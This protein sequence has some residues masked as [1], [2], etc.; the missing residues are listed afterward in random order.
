MKNLLFGIVILGIAFHSQAGSTDVKSKIKE[1]TVFLQGAQISRVAEIQLVSGFSD[2]VFTEL[3]VGLTESSIQVKAKESV[4]IL[5]V[6]YR[7]NDNHEYSDESQISK[8]DKEI[9]NKQFEINK[10]RKQILVYSEEEKILLQNSSFEGIESGVNLEELKLAADYFRARLKEIA[11]IKLDF[12]QEL[13]LLQEESNRL[14]IQK[15]QIQNTRPEPTGEI[16][17]RVETEV[18]GKQKFEI[19]YFIHSAGWIPEYDVRVND[20][21]K[22]LVISVKAK[23][24]QNSG[25]DWEKVSLVLSTD[26]PQKSNQKPTLSP[27]LLRYGQ[28]YRPT[29]VDSPGKGR[30]KGKIVD[31]QTGE[32]LAFANV[33]LESNGR[34]VAGA[35][36]DYD[37]NYIFQ[38]VD[39]GYYDLKVTYVGFQ[40]SFTKGLIVNNDQIRFYD[41]SLESSQEQLAEIIVTDFAIPL[42]DSD[43]ISSGGTLTAEELQRMPNRNNDVLASDVGGIFEDNNVRGARN[44]E[45]LMYV[46]GMRVIGSNEYVPQ[47]QIETPTNIR[48]EI[49]VPYT[50]LSDGEKYVVRIVDHSIPT[51]YEYF[52]A[53]K[54]TEDVFLVAKLTNWSDLNLLSGGSSIYFEGTYMGK[55]FVDAKSTKD[56]LSISVGRDNNVLVVREQIKDFKSLQVIGSNTKET[57]GYK[58]SIRNNRT[59]PVTLTLEDQLPISTLKEITVEPIDI[60][61]ANYNEE[62]GVLQWKLNLENRESKKVS[63]KYSVKYPKTKVLYLE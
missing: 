25:E 45:T 28:P 30:V 48:Y 20:I 55:S 14:K 22:P 12:D 8:I 34:I 58:I 26:N 24:Y 19:G 62:T 63:F 23:V 60:S 57:R 43:N 9:K 6:N 56:T 35:S 36:T 18:T 46:D 40:T 47:Q 50:I 51:E 7:V 1:V 61:T 4:K 38:N 27:W 53:P 2:L 42:I 10:L 15:Q 29:P 49:E 52:C 33:V 32:P 39:A 21:S 41:V 16:I 37:G 54:I 3:P 11:F 13:A 59:I 31:A 5:S 44:D 17:V